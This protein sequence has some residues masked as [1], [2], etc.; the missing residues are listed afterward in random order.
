LKGYRVTN[1]LDLSLKLR[2]DD[3]LGDLLEKST[4][5]A[6]EMITELQ[7]PLGDL[8]NRDRVELRKS[9]QHL[10]IHSNNNTYQTVDT[11]EDDRYLNL[12][13]Q[14]FVLALFCKD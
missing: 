7:L 3:T 10:T 2:V 8:V 11:S 5:C 14:W 12:S 9:A 6:G 4:L 1:L 13:W